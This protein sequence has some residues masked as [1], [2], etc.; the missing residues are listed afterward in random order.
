MLQPK[1]WWEHFWIP[2]KILIEVMLGLRMCVLLCSKETPGLNSYSNGVFLSFLVLHCQ[3]RHPWW[4]RN[5]HVLV[6]SLRPGSPQL[7]DMSSKWM[8]LCWQK[9]R[10]GTRLSSS[11]W[12]GNCIF[13]VAFFSEENHNKNWVSLDR[14][15]VGALFWLGPW[16]WPWWWWTQLRITECSLHHFP[17]LFIASEFSGQLVTFWERAVGIFIGILLKLLIYL[18]VI[19]TAIL[20]RLLPQTHFEFI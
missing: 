10:R 12:N 4:A 15:E 6:A 20:L 17:A 8:S 16:R 14:L 18:R 9:Q 2:K 7:L 11:W 19:V 5:C 3:V 13:Q 1:K